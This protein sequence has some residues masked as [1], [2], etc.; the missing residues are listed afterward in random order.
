MT[1][2]ERAQAYWEAQRN[3]E[4]CSLAEHFKRCENDALEKAARL[5]DDLTDPLGLSTRI[6]NFKR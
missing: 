6:R 4:D 3:A 5:A 1:P 2:K